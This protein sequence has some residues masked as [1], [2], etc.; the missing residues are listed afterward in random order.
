M[1]RDRDYGDMRA[2]A[3]ALDKGEV[4]SVTLVT[5]YLREMFR[6][7]DCWFLLIPIQSKSKTTTRVGAIFGRS[8]SLH[9]RTNV[10]DKVKV[11]ATES[12]CRG[13]TC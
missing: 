11:S 6:E 9:Q 4:S 10:S 5:E 1:R 13:G 3:A 7:E 2:I 12:F 8:W